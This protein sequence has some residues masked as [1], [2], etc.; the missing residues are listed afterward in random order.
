MEG[1]IKLIAGG[2]LYIEMDSPTE[3][4]AG[5]LTPK[6]T[7]LVAFTSKKTEFMTNVSE[8]PPSI[9]APRPTGG[10]LSALKQ[11]DRILVTSAVNLVGI[12]VGEHFD[13]T[14]IEVIR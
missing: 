3:I 9:D 2:A 7:L 10:S 1:I 6:K 14:R 4:S 11:G 5:A 13:A 8:L 12:P